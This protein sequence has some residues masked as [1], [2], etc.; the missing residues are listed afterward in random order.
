MKSFLKKLILFLIPLAII[1]A[2]PAIVLKV[3]GESY[4]SILPFL[5]SDKKHLIGYAYHDSN[6]RY[7]KWAGIQAGEKKQVWTLGSSRVLQFREE[8]FDSSFYNAGYTVRSLNDYIPFMEA[9]PKNKFP[10]YLILGVDHW[11][12][13]KTWDIPEVIPKAELWT[14]SFVFFPEA[15][16]YFKMYFDFYS[17]KY[18]LNAFDE[19]SRIQRIGLNAV[20]NNVGFRNDGTMNY[21]SQIDKLLSN[22]PGAQDYQFATTF[23][24]VKTGYRQFQ[25]GDSIDRDAL[26]KLRRILDYCQKNNV[27][28]VG[29]LP[30]FAD[31]VYQ[32]MLRSKNLNYLHGMADKLKPEFD[33]FGFEFYD[34][35]S[36]SQCG[37]SDD[38]AID[39][40]HGGE[41]TYLKILLKM[42]EQGSVLK[43]VTSKDRLIRDLESGENRYIVYKY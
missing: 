20:V 36:L 27:T 13:T 17:G 8:M 35:S 18:G 10:K 25:P 30:P 26:A 29:F 2:V 6:Y 33:A 5:K 31:S 40:M 37:S 1:A 16:T 4:T 21:G 11:T 7:L 15:S 41:R 38:E 28:V 14:E 43:N 23:N 24:K 39:G 34:C 19:D 32:E 22:D 12:F 9:L 42:L 3:S